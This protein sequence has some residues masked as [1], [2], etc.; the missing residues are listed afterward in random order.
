MMRY[1]RSDD[2]TTR[3][4]VVA[5]LQSHFPRPK[6]SF[7]QQVAGRPSVVLVVRSVVADKH[8]H[9][10]LTRPSQLDPAGAAPVPPTHPGCRESPQVSR[11]SAA[12]CR[13]HRSYSRIPARLAIVLPPPAI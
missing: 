2:R 3:F 1:G 8:N 5:R 11:A 6:V 13:T 7:A 4:V 10:L 12:P 9:S